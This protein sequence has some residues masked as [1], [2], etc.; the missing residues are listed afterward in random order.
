[1]FCLFEEV[2][3]QDCAECTGSAG[4]KEPFDCCCSRGTKPDL[5]IL[6]K[7][8][9]G[10]L[11]PISAVLGSQE[12]MSVLTSGTHGSTFGGNAIASAV[13]IEALR[14]LREEKL[15]ENSFAMGK[16]FRANLEAVARLPAVRE[17]RGRG[18]FNAIEVVPGATKRT[19]WEICLALAK[20]G[21]R[22]KTVCFLFVKCLFIRSCANQRTITLFV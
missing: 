22:E 14:V 3:K 13:A 6:G 11:Y 1:V 17:V 15:V 9:S 12:V 4:S 20:R 19:A 7:A 8:L 10:G 16:R 5:L 18:L 21:V 2:G